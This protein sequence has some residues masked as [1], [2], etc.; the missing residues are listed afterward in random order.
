ML[1]IRRAL[2]QFD[3]GSAAG[4]LRQLQQ[5][6]GAPTALSSLGM[7]RAGIAEAVE[8]ALQ[9]PYPNPR[10]LDRRSL[11]QLLEQAFDGRPPAL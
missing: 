10:P 1:R 8:A 7:P 4:G 9:Q 11:L 6:L 3:T 2:G 5:V